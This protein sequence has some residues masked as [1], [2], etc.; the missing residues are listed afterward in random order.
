[1]LADWDE[2]R[3]RWCPHVV[4]LIPVRTFD[5]DGRP[6]PQKIRIKCEYCN[7]EHTVVCLT[8]ATRQH[9]TNFAIVHQHQLV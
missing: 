3:P 8:G 4:G 7:T 2:Y 5:D 1:M 6:E 9:V